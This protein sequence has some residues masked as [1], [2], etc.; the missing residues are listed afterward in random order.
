MRSYVPS[1]KKFQNTH[2]HIHTSGKT[3]CLPDSIP[4]RTQGNANPVGIFRWCT[5]RSVNWFPKRTPQAAAK[6]DTWPDVC[7]SVACFS[8]AAVSGL[9]AFF[10]ICFR[11]AWTP[12]QTFLKKKTTGLIKRHCGGNKGEK[13]LNPKHVN[14]VSCGILIFCSFMQCSKNLLLSESKITNSRVPKST[15]QGFWFFDHP[16]FMFGPFSF[17]DSGP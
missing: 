9:A 11:C 1:K 15:I 16:N 10:L 13:I 5:S 17:V 6:A 12:I 8:D 4:Y 2:T 7:C 3:S 14:F